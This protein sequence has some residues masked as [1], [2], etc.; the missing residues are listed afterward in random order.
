MWKSASDREEALQQAK[1]EYNEI[2]EDIKNEARK[3]TNKAVLKKRDSYVTNRVDDLPYTAFAEGDTNIIYRHYYEKLK[4]NHRSKREEITSKIRLLDSPTRNGKFMM[5]E[6]K[7]SQTPKKTN[8]N[9][10]EAWWHEPDLGPSHVIIIARAD[11]LTPLSCAVL[12]AMKYSHCVLF[13]TLHHKSAHE[14]TSMF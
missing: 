13:A 2:E 6:N 9:R 7:R 12:A 11:D 10:Y 5:V 8:Y 3:L 1:D 4:K 14:T